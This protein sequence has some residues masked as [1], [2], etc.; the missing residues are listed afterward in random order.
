MS[1]LLDRAITAGLFVVLAFTAL[2]H[3]AVEPWSVAVWEMTVALLILMWGVKWAVDKRISLK[4][5]AA[6]LPFAGLL[7]L[8]IAQSAV[9]G[10]SMD[11][12]ATRSATLALVSAFSIFMIGSNF[13]GSRRRL[14]AAANFLV[15]LG[16][17]LAV[18][19]LIQHFTWNGSLYWFRPNTQTAS[20]FGPFVNHN[21]FAGLIGMIIPLAIALAASDIGLES[22]LFYGFAAAVMGIASVLALSRGGMISLT[23]A[24]AFVVA[25]AAIRR[26]Q[27]SRDETHDQW[28]AGSGR[29]AGTRRKRSIGGPALLVLMIVI[30]IGAGIFWIGSDPVIS[31][32]AK[33]ASSPGPD[34]TETFFTSR[35]WIWRDTIAMIEANPILGVGLGAYQTAYPMYS[36]SDG[37]LIVAQSHNDYL[38][39]VADAGIVGGALALWF[40]IIVG[41]TLFNAAKAQDPVVSGLAIGGAGGIFAMLSHSL[42]DFNLQ[43]PSNGLL[44]LT[45]VAVQSNL[46]A[47]AS[48][49]RVKVY[50]KH[51]AR[52]EGASLDH[53]AAAATY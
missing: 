16:L 42:F 49:R 38:Q 35:G 37:S 36:A 53:D 34:K 20:P 30:T 4:V 44:F 51:E 25:M 48:R 19:G 27:H 32:V 8:G 12:E 43:L 46:A 40:L 26:M 5:P 2:A 18:F 24:L 31:R 9:S 6:A 21:H 33:V 23:A 17:G 14:R 52:A 22:R 39:I 11:A 47:V 3:G 13:L 50:R 15:A 28:S 7:A 29:K 10:L 1:A 45:L 41:R